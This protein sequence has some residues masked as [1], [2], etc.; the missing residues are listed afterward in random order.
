M[1]TSALLNI[2]GLNPRS[3]I[4][5]SLVMHMTKYNTQF[6]GLI[7]TRLKPGHLPNH[8]RALDMTSLLRLIH[9]PLLEVL[10]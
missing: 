3:E 1:Q 5:E 4:P 6:L 7:E 2:R 8:I 10:P 9:T